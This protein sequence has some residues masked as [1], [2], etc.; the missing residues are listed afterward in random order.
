MLVRLHPGSSRE[1]IK[2]TSKG[3]EVWIKEKPLEGKA[4]V[5]LVKLFKKHLKMNIKI[6]KGLKSRNKIIE[7]I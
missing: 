3:Y 1:E 5:A 6:I 4:N 7:V 2:K